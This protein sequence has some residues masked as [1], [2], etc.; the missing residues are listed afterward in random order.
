M[1]QAVLQESACGDS[2][3]LDIRREN[4]GGKSVRVQHK[5]LLKQRET[6]NYFF[7]S[8]NGPV[9]AFTFA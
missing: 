9:V 8:V 2:C 6:K 3:W 5:C 1:V 4:W 7:K